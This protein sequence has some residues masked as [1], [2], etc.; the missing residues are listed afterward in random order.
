[1][2]AAHCSWYQFVICGLI[3]NPKDLK[4]GLAGRTSKSESK[5][6]SRAFKSKSKFLEPKSKSSKS[7][8]KSR[9]ESKSRL[10]YYKS[11]TKNKLLPLFAVSTERCHLIA[12]F[13]D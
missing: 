11:A 6:K 4:K 3:A 7:G 2:Y 1:M 8:L 9:L 12:L 13:S 10:E 5:S